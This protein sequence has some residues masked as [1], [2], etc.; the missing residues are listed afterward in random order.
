MSLINTIYYILF[1]KIIHKGNCKGNI[2]FFFSDMVIFFWKLRIKKSIFLEQPRFYNWSSDILRD[3]AI[4]KR[5]L[6]DI[7]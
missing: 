1:L 5:L 7:L 4:D 6:Y 2:S 3:E